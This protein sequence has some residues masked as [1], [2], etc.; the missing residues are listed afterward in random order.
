M[1]E[2]TGGTTTL[3]I[4][5]AHMVLS[6]ARDAGLPTPEMALIDHRCLTVWLCDLLRRENSANPAPWIEWLG[7]TPRGDLYEGSHY[8]LPVQL[9]V[10]ESQPHRPCACS[11][12]RTAA[13]MGPEL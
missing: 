12:C 7:A 3:P 2:S 4:D 6:A 1:D 9:F 13:Q 8:D 10:A 11:T 5:G